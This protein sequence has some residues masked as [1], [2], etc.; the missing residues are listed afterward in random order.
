MCL[1][2]VGTRMLLEAIETRRPRAQIV[3]ALSRVA[4]AV[5]GNDKVGEGQMTITESVRRQSPKSGSIDI[6]GMTS[7][8]LK[9]PASPP[10][11]GSE[12][13]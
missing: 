12:T 6:F 4:V 8:W 2:G 7:G 3:E 5:R 1:T 9:R 11:S 13:A 10:T